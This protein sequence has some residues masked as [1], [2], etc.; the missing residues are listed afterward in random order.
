[1]KLRVLMLVIC[2]I[3]IFQGISLASDYQKIMQ[4][5]DGIYSVDY[6]VRGQHLDILKKCYG[7]KVIIKDGHLNDWTL[8][9]ENIA[10]S[11]S[12]EYIVTCTYLLKGFGA[13]PPMVEAKLFIKLSDNEITRK[14]EHQEF[15]SSRWPN[16]EWKTTM[17]FYR[18][19]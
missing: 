2:L 9:V 12:D 19:D 4:T 13:P 15:I 16:G 18:L 3:F 8:N 5:M 10:K 6:H 14:I 7:E 17:T 11:A 1:M